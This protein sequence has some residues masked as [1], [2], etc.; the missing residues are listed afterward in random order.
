MWRGSVALAVFRLH[1]MMRLTR[2]PILNPSTK[3]LL[4][5]AFPYDNSI[6]LQHYSLFSS[7]L[8]MALN[9]SNNL[10]WPYRLHNS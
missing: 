3:R 5:Y 2:K 7:G 10:T 4:G 8:E 9:R 6:Q 1:V